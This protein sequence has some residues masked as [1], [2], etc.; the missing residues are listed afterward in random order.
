[1]AK[2]L[3]IEDLISKFSPEDIQK[4]LL[5]KQQKDLAPRKMKVADEWE[6]LKTESTAIREI[7]PSWTLPWKKSGSKKGN[8]GVQ[9]VDGDL[10]KLQT[11]LGNETK[12]LKE[13]AAHLNAPW[14][15]VKKFL[16]VYPAFKLTT[17][18]KKSFLSYTQK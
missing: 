5:A 1:M 13:A 7:D 16:K 14:Q 9:L 12:P 8:S 2:Q 11:F 6:A 15:S 17:K 4:A 18:D 3:T 10:L